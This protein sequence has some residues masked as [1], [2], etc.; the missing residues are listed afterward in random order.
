VEVGPG[1]HPD[2]SAPGRWCTVTA[3]ELDDRLVEHLRERFADE[4]RLTLLSADFL[5]VEV[6]SVASGPWALVANVPYHIT[7]PSCTTSWRPRRGRRAFVL[8]SSVR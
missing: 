2:R 1:W 6:A 4:P 3:V 5:D 8:S 7:S